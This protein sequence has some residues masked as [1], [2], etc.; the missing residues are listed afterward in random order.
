MSPTVARRGLPVR[1][2]L[3]GRGLNVYDLV[4]A[5]GIVAL[6]YVVMQARASR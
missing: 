3:R 2:V 5:V 4:L 6:G 1:E